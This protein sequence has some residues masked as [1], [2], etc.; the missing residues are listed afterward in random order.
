MAFNPNA[1]KEKKW[2]T[3][4]VISNMI[5]SQVETYV[6]VN[7]GT[8]RNI[9]TGSGLKGGPITENGTISLDANISDLNDIN[10]TNLAT[11]QALIY[12]KENSRWVNKT[13]L[14]DQRIGGRIPPG[15]K[16]INSPGPHKIINYDVLE[17]VSELPTSIKPTENNYIITINP[18][19]ESTNP[20]LNLGSGT[21]AFV[22]NGVCIT[23]SR[24]LSLVRGLR[25]KFYADNF[26]IQSTENFGA[27]DPDNL[28]NGFTSSY[29]SS[30]N[31]FTY[32]VP[33]FETL[34]T[35]YTGSSIVSLGT[36]Y[37]G[38]G[39]CIV[40]NNYVLNERLVPIYL[41]TF[42]TGNRIELYNSKLT[43]YGGVSEVEYS[44][45]GENFGE[46][47]YIQ[48]VGEESNSKNSFLVLK[49][50]VSSF[51]ISNNDAY[52]YEGENVK[53]NGGTGQGA[54]ARII[55]ID[56]SEGKTHQ[57]VP[58]GKAKDINIILSGQNYSPGD[59]LSITSTNSHNNKTET[60]I[61]SGTSVVYSTN[62]GVSWSL[63][64]MQDGTSV[65]NNGFGYGVGYGNGR[66][67]CAGNDTSSNNYN[68][69]YSDNGISW[70]PVFMKDGSSIFGTGYA[71]DVAYGDGTWIAVGNDDTN[72]YNV[73]YSTDHGISWS[74]GYPTTG[75]SVFGTSE[76][77][78]IG[79]HDDLWVITGNDDSGNN[80]NIYYSTDKGV[81]WTP[82]YTDTSTSVFGT[83]LGYDVE[84]GNA[85][86]LAG[87]ENSS[88]EH[89][90]YTSSNGISWS[91]V[92]AFGIGGSVRG[93]G[94]SNFLWLATGKDNSGN[95]DNII[96]SSDGV[97]WKPS[98][99]KVFG[100]G[101]GN[102]ISYGN[103]KW[104]AT[105]EDGVSF[106]NVIYSTNLGLSWSPAFMD[107]ATGTSVFGTGEG[108]DIIYGDGIVSTFITLN[109]VI[110][111]FIRYSKFT[112]LSDTPDTFVDGSYLVS[113]STGLYYKNVQSDV[114][115]NFN[116]KQITVNSNSYN[117]GN[118]NNSINYSSSFGKDNSSS[119]YSTAIGENNIAINHSFASGF[120]S[121]ASN[122]SSA[123]GVGLS[124]SEGSMAIGFYNDQIFQ[125]TSS[126]FY[127]G[128]GTDSSNKSNKIAIG[129]SFIID[130]TILPT[131]STG[132]PSG[133]LYTQ[134]ISGVSV[135]AIVP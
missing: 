63:G 104:L 117:F 70:N 47:S 17:G 79:Y 133:C 11:D 33:Y 115:T 119:N 135:L 118:S 19:R 108:N 41:N 7:P 42:D 130:T 6:G 8:V 48:L 32:D 21:S 101:Y 114:N 112:N 125:G 98:N 75:T 97:C 10:F 87:G 89:N 111:P 46:N 127:I 43:N 61:S 82:A 66:W 64:T 36:C 110:N 35:V 81:C 90:L 78:G 65:F 62:N 59:R 14:G 123:L 52:F 60:W 22:I 67:F 25:Y 53:I 94:Y 106:N 51:E 124:V 13:F 132:L 20:Y 84:Y 71:N 129:T 120:G 4:P 126:C 2:T 5:R 74:P 100:N 31:V 99:T 23:E 73:I 68:L 57:K 55:T 69:V 128:D 93:L 102:N 38:F 72:N 91:G 24:P 39:M 107:D 77:Y 103:N 113:S 44:Q 15:N 58:V 50:G 49:K 12:D 109:Q 95:Q 86:W 105:G 9:F 134:F 56:T 18:T 92:S 1:R 116:V 131:S 121:C 54:E 34:D 16:T 40:S 85:I 45:I 76:G 88:T 30:G 28:V 26:Y 122:D 80:H 27:Y 83:G 29:A 96:Y 37:I 3:K